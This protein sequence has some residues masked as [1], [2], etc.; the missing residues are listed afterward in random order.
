MKE[1]NKLG[2]IVSATFF[3]WCAVMYLF[4]KWLAG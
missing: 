3:V 4:C 1:M 2:C